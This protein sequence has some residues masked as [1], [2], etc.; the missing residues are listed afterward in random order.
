MTDRFSNLLE[1][2]ELDQSRPARF[3]IVYAGAAPLLG[4]HLEIRAQLVIQVLLDSS[5]EHDVPQEAG[6]ARAD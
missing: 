3:S 1:T 2:S 4:H 6:N 5:P